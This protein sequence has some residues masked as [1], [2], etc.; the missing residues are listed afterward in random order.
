MM[1]T[2]TDVSEE[3]FATWAD[4]LVCPVCHAMDEGCDGIVCHGLDAD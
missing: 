2:I 4:E 3:T 1:S